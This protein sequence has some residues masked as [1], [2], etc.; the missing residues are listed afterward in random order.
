MQIIKIQTALLKS[1]I[2]AILIFSTVTLF[3]QAVITNETEVKHLDIMLTNN[4]VTSIYQDHTGYM[5]FGT[6][7]GLNRFDGINVKKFYPDPNNKNSL[8]DYYIQDIESDSYGNL[9]ISTNNGLN[10][11]NSDRENFT[12]Y[13][14]NPGNSNS[15]SS[16]SL[17]DIL[18]DS[19]KRLWII[20]DYIS[21]YNYDEDNFINFKIGISDIDEERADSYNRIFEDS[22]GRIWFLFNK[23]IYY[24]S[25]E[26]NDMV[27]FFN[28]NNNPL[29]ELP[30][31]FMN[32]VQIDDDTFWL[33]AYNAGIIKANLYKSNQ[34]EKLNEFKGI[35]ASELREV[36][37]LEMVMDSKKQI[38]ISAENQ[39]VYVF[40]NQAG[41]VKRFVYDRDNFN[42]ISFNSIWS[43]FEDVAGRYWLGTW[44]SGIDL[45]DKHYRKFVHYKYMPG[46]NSLSHDIVK[47][48][49]EDAKGNLYIATDGGGLNYLNRET[50]RFSEYIH[51]ENDP[52]SIS[53]DA[54]LTLEY[55]N[56][57]NLWMGTWNGGINVFDS[58][59]QRFSKF[60]TANSKLCSANIFDIVFDGDNTM[61]IATWGG[62]LCKYNIRTNTWKTYGHNPEEPNTICSNYIYSMFL[63]SEEKLWI[64]TT[65]GLDV[66][67]I[68]TDDAN[69]IH[70][71]ANESDSTTISDNTIN[72][73]YE[74][75]FA[76]IWVGAVGGLNL[77]N[78]EANNFS[79]IDKRDGLIDDNI[80]SILYD[81]SNYY[82]L[83][84]NRGLVRFD[85]DN[86][87]FRHYDISDGMQ[88]YEFS[89]NA[90]IML[91]S[92]E[93]AI[94]G[95][96]G[97]NIFHPDKIIENPLIPKIVFTD[98]KVFNKSIMTGENAQL[99]HHINN[100]D[101]VTLDYTQNVF[102]IEF[103]A[104]NYTHP[105]KNQYAYI[106]EGFDEE[107]INVTNELKATYTNLSPGEYTFRV[108]GS[109]NDGIWNEE[110][111]S[112]EIVITPP[113]W[114]TTWFRITAILVFIALV[115]FIYLWR[116]RK[117]H[118]SKKELELKIN[119]ATA[120][121]EARN[122]K[123][124]EAKTTLNVIINEVKNNLGH[125]SN[126]LL[127]A[128]KSQSSSVNELSSTIEQMTIE[129]NEN[130]QKA[131]K[132]FDR[133]KNV[134]DNA[135]ESLGTIEEA[136]GFIQNISNEVSFI[137]EIAQ[138]TKFLSLNAS[139]EAAR[140]GEH[141]KSFAVV[142]N[143]VKKLSERSQ[144]VANNI[145]S[146]TSSGLQLSQEANK[147]INDLVGF[148]ENIVEATGN[149]I[150]FIENQSE[151]TEAINSTVK[152]MSDFISKTDGLVQELDSAI[153]SLALNDEL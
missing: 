2:T 138:K 48:I 29:S 72:T 95:T 108:K 97:M 33:S 9:W 110:D 122:T 26:T 103:V 124:E 64:G 19:Q 115:L 76:N 99:K 18:F 114:A 58:K 150:E 22:H 112:V 100:I 146:L 136:V 116:T 91:S 84:T 35:E 1:S 10:K 118:Q 65:D 94:G 74:D 34:L 23:E 49:I 71:R 89:R 73:I 126:K 135:A 50:G 87:K 152:E 133:S 107:W 142:A 78:A 66:F 137:L 57:G 83:G 101:K 56:N 117:L 96:T 38:W 46:I 5:W 85:F 93:T 75:E 32:I 21:L 153:N 24:Y 8:T 53:A 80:N 36:Q 132:V 144:E 149:I 128:S 123:L 88:G 119:Q 62:G 55:D 90:S 51:N 81:G 54:V 14:H 41:L 15:I 63:D 61:Y 147:K 25:T 143:E 145:D 102:T 86:M 141:G 12:Q 98:F 4:T 40:N 105:E 16:G 140:A 120:E 20:G 67:N 134:Q 113:I 121:L 27:L 11:Y 130:T 131:N 42:S 79:R 59:T 17:T 69:F 70:Y 39:G 151:K 109:N 106:M 47:D 28:G 68:K 52:N 43:V 13:L 6:Y 31:Y 127:E 37:L 148:I 104:L 30:W 77:Y 45:I 92:G 129:I 7:N 111:I 139:I 44:Q 3:G 125:A 82:W 60:T